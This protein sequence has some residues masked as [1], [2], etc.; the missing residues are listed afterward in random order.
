MHTFGE[1]VGEQRKGRRLT[2]D[3]LAQ[4]VGCSVAMLRKIEADARRPSAQIAAL[5]AHAFA[6]PPAER[7]TFVRVARGELGV[8]RLTPDAAKPPP[9]QI[10]QA[11]ASLRPNLPLSPA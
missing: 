8:D 11:A 5:L 9:P 6:T 2:R 3:E 4:R 10:A 7:T 1:W